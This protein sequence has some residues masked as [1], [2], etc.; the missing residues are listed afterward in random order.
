M[1]YL[2][3]AVVLSKSPRYFLALIALKLL[4][5]LISRLVARSARIVADKQTNKQTHRTTTVTLAAHAR[6]GLIS[7][8]ADNSVGHISSPDSARCRLPASM[9]GATCLRWVG[10]GSQAS[11]EGTG[12]VT[13]QS[14]AP[15]KRR[16]V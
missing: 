3:N 15:T 16:I 13:M 8:L 1:T 5:S 11:S 12:H 7:S 6:R 14:P 4:V 10:L 9:R 2:P